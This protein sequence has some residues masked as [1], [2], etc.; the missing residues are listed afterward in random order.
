MNTPKTIML[1]LKN[2]VSIVC[3]FQEKAVIVVIQ[4]PIFQGCAVAL[5]GGKLRCEILYYQNPGQRGETESALD[6]SAL[7][8]QSTPATLIS[9]E[10]GRSIFEASYHVVKEP[11]QLMS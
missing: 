8:L 2:I 4:L 1:I 7:L 9:S 5:V 3:H 11:P 10:V 6:K